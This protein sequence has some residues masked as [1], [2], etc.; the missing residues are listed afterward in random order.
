MEN[1]QGGQGLQH[2][3]YKVMLR[4]LDQLSLMKRWQRDRSARPSTWVVDTEEMEPDLKV[5]S[6]RITGNE[7]K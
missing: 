7:H 1:K 4:D 2:V 3:A 5:H 6:D